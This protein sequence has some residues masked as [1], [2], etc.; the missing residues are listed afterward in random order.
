VSSFEAALVAVSVCFHVVSYERNAI[1][2]A[3]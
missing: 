1:M 3:Q 2:C